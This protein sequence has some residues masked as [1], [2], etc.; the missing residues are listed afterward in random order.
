MNVFITFSVAAVVMLE[1]QTAYPGARWPLVVG[2]LVALVVYAWIA[3]N[4]KLSNYINTQGSDDEQF[5]KR[6]GT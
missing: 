2:V 1:L 5:D 3:Y 4:H 6:K